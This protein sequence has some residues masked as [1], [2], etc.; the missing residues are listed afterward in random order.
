MQLQ[1]EDNKATLI[2]YEAFPKDAGTY[3]VSAKNIAGEATSSCSVS[4]KG[5][6]PTETSDSEMASDMEPVKPSIQ[7]PLTN[8]TVTEGNRIRLDCVIVGQP[9]PEVIWYHDDRPVKE[10][11]DFQLLF[12]GD[13]CSLVIQEALPED[14]GEYKVVALNS[15]G[16]ASS[17]CILS[18]TP[19]AESDAET[20]PTE[21]ATKPA[22]T[23]PK[24]TKLL[25]DILVSEGDKV[26][27]EGNV[28]GEPRP[29]IKW[30][31][32]N[33]PITDTQHFQITHDDESNVKLEIEQVRPEDK[34]VYTVKASNSAGEAKC[35]AQLIVKALKP[36]DTVKHEELKLP[37][38]FKETFSDRI[39]FEDTN[40]KFECIVTGKP[41]PKVKWLFNGDAISGKDF[42]ISTS[43][44]RQVLSIPTLK[45]E[46]SGTITC[47]AENEVGKSSCAAVLTVQ[48]TSSVALPE[49]EI[50]TT[51]VPV[52]SPLAPL[53]SEK[54]QHLET[55][56][57][58]NREVVTQTSTSQASKIISSESSEP[59]TEEHK[60]TSQ[61]AQSFKQINQEAPQIKESHRIEE[62]HK[63]GKEPP[64]IHEKSSTTYSIGEQ[65]DIQS[66]IKS[67]EQLEIIQKPLLRIRPPRFVTPVIGK[68]I[69]QNVDVV[70]E[71][72]LDGQPTPQISWTKNGE[73]LKPNERVKI[74]WGH[75]RASVEIKNATVE[76][77]G[78]YSC[79]AVNEGGTAVST[80]DLVVRS[81][82]HLFK[83]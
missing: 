28:V 26:I 9:E 27:L 42:L 13:R 41:V 49:F 30:L 82:F 60:I 64:V 57:I 1:F 75:N 31:L 52:I 47:V 40:T 73:E 68:I 83:I 18:V 22:G 74:N 38:E 35:F 62:Y 50:K 54:T 36:V 66:Q 53:K 56:Y 70:L 15:A 11:Q 10:S 3:L 4:V 19:I 14:A 39:A 44:D 2:I 76:D 59:H 32:N 8:T 20:K 25:A 67:S 51:P 17:K 80:A 21:E 23:A 61:N 46:H 72:I 6:L 45:K 77:A 16:E 24:F 78:R 43:G 81:A 58:I 33:L 63:V 79:T 12:Q 34:G 55:S 7:L 48:P 65:R 5:R 37:P 69:D 71:G 29:E